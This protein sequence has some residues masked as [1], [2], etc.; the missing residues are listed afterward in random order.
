MLK[1]PV[2]VNS[3]K[4]EIKK[5]CGSEGTAKFNSIITDELREFEMSKLKNYVSISPHFLTTD[6]KFTKEPQFMPG[7]EDMRGIV[8]E[9]DAGE[10]LKLM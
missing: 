9:M 1:N 5:Y 2:P 3:E 6:I 10:V 4:K 7:L 8:S